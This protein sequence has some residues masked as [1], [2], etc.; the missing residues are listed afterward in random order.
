MKGIHP[1]Y[2]LQKKG[3]EM[4]KLINYMNI[5]APKEA[6]EISKDRLGDI[7]SKV[8]KDKRDYDRLDREVKAYKAAYSFEFT[9]GDV[10]EEYKK[11]N[12]MAMKM[13][14]MLNFL[15]SEKRS[16][17]A[18]GKEF[19]EAVSTLRRDIPIKAIGREDEYL[20]IKTPRVKSS[21][22]WYVG[23]YVTTW[24]VGAIQLLLVPEGDYSISQTKMMLITNPVKDKINLEE[25]F[26]YNLKHKPDNASITTVLSDI[27][28]DGQEETDRFEAWLIALVN[29]AIYVYSQDPE[30]DNLK[31][32]KL[33]TPKELGR[34]TSDVKENLCT[35]PVHLV[36]WNYHTGKQYTTDKAFVH[37]H[38]RWQPCGPGRQELKLVWVKE[39]VRHYNKEER[40]GESV[41]R[42]SSGTTQGRGLS[43]TR[44]ENPSYETVSADG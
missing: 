16:V 29:T 38:M 34:M 5:I 42:Q 23:C 11:T 21:G 1:E 15:E 28:W 18:V 22:V 25:D 12:V 2:V 3:D 7:A 37:S 44:S 20:Y 32:L 14:M 31:P 24:D 27:A 4:D 8:I 39:H 17:Y 41:Q 43:E 30:I 35:L 10:P 9:Y 13:K 19:F 36:N 6:P 40:N 33:Y 26:R